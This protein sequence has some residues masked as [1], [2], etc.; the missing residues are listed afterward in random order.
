MKI[1]T[2][3]YNG[4]ARMGYVPR[5][6]MPVE[7]MSLPEI[8]EEISQYAYYQKEPLDF[9]LSTDLNEKKK[10]E[11]FL[12]K[13]RASHA[14]NSAMGAARDTSLLASAVLGFGIMAEMVTPSYYQL[15]V[16]TV[17]L[18][19][20]IANRMGRSQIH[21]GTKEFL[22]HRVVEKLKMTPS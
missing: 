20:F 10:A 6:P 1:L 17:W 4:L 14:S 21:D 3:L 15:A 18:T 9:V 12:Q 13:T 19:L 16:P 7:E 2:I 22:S 5:N 8:Y 11:K